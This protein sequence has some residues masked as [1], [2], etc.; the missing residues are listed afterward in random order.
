[1]TVKPLIFPRPSEIN[2][3]A[4]EIAGGTIPAKWLEDLAAYPAHTVAVP[5][6]ISN[7]II[8][9]RAGEDAVRPRPQPVTETTSNIGNELG[10]TN[11]VSLFTLVAAAASRPVHQ[12]SGPIRLEIPVMVNPGVANTAVEPFR[13]IVPDDVHG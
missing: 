1:M 3:T 8:E 11:H 4:E 13:V 5:V 10:I 12:S 9:G 2:E 6:V 7:A